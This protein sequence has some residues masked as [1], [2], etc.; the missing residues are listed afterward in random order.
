VSKKPGQR[1]PGKASARMAA[2]AQVRERERLAA[3]LPGGAPDRPIEVAS[4][5]VVEVRARSIP[6][7]QCGGELDVGEHGATTHDGDA[8]RVVDARCRRC[9]APR[10][11]YFRLTVALPN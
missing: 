4:A 9:G 1:K 11:L 2:R 3:L 8:L 10:T 7:P 6:C 5:A